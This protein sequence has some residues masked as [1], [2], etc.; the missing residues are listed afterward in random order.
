MLKV[1]SGGKPV[2]VSEM[3]S[4]R[5]GLRPSLVHSGASCP[6][7]ETPFSKRSLAPDRAGQVRRACWK[8]SGPIPP[9]GQVGLGF[10]ANQ[11]GW[12]AR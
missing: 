11:E 5:A 12:A 4:P 9:P 3:Y 6:R 10:S 2:F 7:E 8:D 1:M